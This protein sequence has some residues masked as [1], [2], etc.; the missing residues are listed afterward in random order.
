MKPELDAQL[1]KDHPILFASRYAD[2]RTTAMCWGFECGDGWY[3]L[4]KEAADKLE[5]LCRADYEKYAPLEKAWY[6]HIRNGIAFTAK[7]PFIFSVL[8]KIVNS[9]QPNV[10]N[11]PLYYYGGPP[12]ALQVKEKFGTLRFYMTHQTEEM[13]AIITEAER[14]SSVTC[15]E[16]GKPGKVIGGGWLYCRCRECYQKLIDQGYMCGDYDEREEDTSGA[17]D[18]A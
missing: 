3:G 13:D 14:K 7:V 15:E 5:P 8:Y 12:R 18:P 16:C 1:V 6:K 17:D 9:I 2:M 4:L 10:Y 11:S